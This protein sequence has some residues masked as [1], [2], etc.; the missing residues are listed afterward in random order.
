M[1]QS[2]H[3]AAVNKIIVLVV[4]IAGASGIGHAQTFLKTKM[5]NAKG[6]LV[7]VDLSFDERSRR[8]TLESR[9][10]TLAES[11]PYESID[12]LSYRLA[13]HHRVRQ[14]SE[15]L[16]GCVGGLY[17]APSF[18]LLCGASLIAG[19]AV[20]FSR[21][22]NHWFYVH[23]QQDGIAKEL[24][25]KLDKSE[26]QQVLRAAGEQSGKSVEILMAKK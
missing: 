15:L 7:S 19:P 4:G 18:L 9:K 10:L 22:K 17:S 23:Y 8:L 3:Q 24:T 11:I 1:K 13:A 25:L 21:E 20:M 2:I 26:Y 12:K 5:F 16:H 14:G 6:K